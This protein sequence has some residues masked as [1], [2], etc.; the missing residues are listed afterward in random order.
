MFLGYIY[1]LI[2]NNI[3]MFCNMFYYWV[4]CLDI[5]SEIILRSWSKRFTWDQPFLHTIINVS[6]P[7]LPPSFS[8]YTRILPHMLWSMLVWN[9]SI[10]KMGS[11]YRM[12]LLA[13]GF[14]TKMR[15]WGWESAMYLSRRSLQLAEVAVARSLKMA[16]SSVA[17]GA[18]AASA[19]ANVWELVAFAVAVA[20]ADSCILSNPLMSPDMMLPVSY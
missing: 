18:V 6:T 8:V 10:P 12:L 7:L 4:I 17:S 16:R 19:S 13:Q 1:N 15:A 3:Q 11:I 14:T 2:Y 9:G 20:F 5:T